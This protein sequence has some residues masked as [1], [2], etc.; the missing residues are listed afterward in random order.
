MPCLDWQMR[1]SLLRRSLGAFWDALWM[2]SY[3]W[4]DDMIQDLRY[5][6]RILFKQPAFTLIDS[7]SLASSAFSLS[8]L[9]A[10]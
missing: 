4:E 6:I 3:R 5:G 9:S 1:F 8:R 7:N 2:Q 10:R